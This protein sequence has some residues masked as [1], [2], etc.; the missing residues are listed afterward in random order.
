METMAMKHA[1]YVDPVIRV[2]REIGL[3]ISSL[4]KNEYLS[5]SPLHRAVILSQHDL[6]KDFIKFV[7]FIFIYTSTFS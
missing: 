4:N 2:L 1:T 5:I 6:L 3:N 7:Y